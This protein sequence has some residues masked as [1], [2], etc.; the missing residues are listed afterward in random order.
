MSPLN[1]RRAVALLLCIALIALTGCVSV[2]L[3]PEGDGVTIA[4][5][6]ELVTAEYKV[7]EYEAVDLRGSLNVVYSSA[8]SDTV[9]VS[10][11]EN[12][13]EHL[14]V[15]VESGVL[16]V[17]A[18]KF[19]VVF[20]KQ[21]TVTISRPGLSSMSISG[22][23]DMNRSDT[24]TAPKFSLNVSGGCSIDMALAVDELTINVSGAASLKLFGQAQRFSAETSGAGDIN[25]KELKTISARFIMSGASDASID[26]QD[27]LDVTI[28]GAGS[29][30]YRGSP[31]V[32]QSIS[33][34][35]SVER[36]D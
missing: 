28:N 25:A 11:Q 19:V 12:L 16:I 8:P 27:S 21:P 24:L 30:K 31:S 32:R 15:R 7:G 26:C 2:N 18:S 14:D 33:G 35:G 36:I 29:L 20:D 9:T 1:L 34:V 23:V 13:R 4:G 3:T 6:G 10:L 17:D 22:A 5:V